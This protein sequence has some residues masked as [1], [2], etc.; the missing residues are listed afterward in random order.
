VLAEDPDA[1]VLILP[2]DHFILP[3]RK[4][5]ATAKQALRLAGQDPNRI[6]LL[7]AVP[8]SPTA[9]YGWIQKGK[10][11]AAPMRSGAS[12]VEAFIEKPG[13]EKA[14]QLYK[15]GWLWNTMIF[16]AKARLIWELSTRFDRAL[17][18]RFDFYRR[19][20]AAVNE[21]RVP[22]SHRRLALRHLYSDMRSSDFSRDLAQ[23]FPRRC[24]VL[25]MEGVYWTDCGHPLRLAKLIEQHGETSVAGV[26][27]RECVEV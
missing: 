20:L 19:A 9:D 17:T 23:R 27:A 7:G 13:T 6:V 2:S 24:T 5:A 16:A 10:P 14:N 21:K 8:D 3:D 18:A 25:P 4:F 1:T 22:P 15:Q 12:A 11:A 26:A